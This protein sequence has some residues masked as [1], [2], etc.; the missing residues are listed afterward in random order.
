MERKMTKSVT[1][2]QFLHKS[3][4]RV[5]A[6]WYA[7]KGLAHRRVRNLFVR[8][9]GKSVHPGPRAGIKRW[10]RFHRA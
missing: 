10:M 1:V 8:I 3:P 4:A 5:L 2:A 6:A 7:P 9:N